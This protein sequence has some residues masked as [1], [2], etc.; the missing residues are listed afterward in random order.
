MNLHTLQRPRP[1]D[2]LVG[3][4]AGATLGFVLLGIGGRAGMRIVALATGQ[5]PSFTVVGSLAVSLLGAVAGAFVATV[6]L[7]ARTAFPTRRW[8]RGALFWVICAAIFLRG[9]RPVTPLNAGV[10]LPLFLLHGAL[11]HTFWCRVHLARSSTSSTPA[12]HP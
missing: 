11:L 10:F 3:L 6:F 9:L 7:L 1:R 4:A 8:V 12:S 2:W 5:S